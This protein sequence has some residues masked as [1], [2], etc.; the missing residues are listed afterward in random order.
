MVCEKRVKS[1]EEKAAKLRLDV[2]NAVKAAGK[3]HIGGAFSMMDLLVALYHGRF[4][5]YDNNSAEA[6]ARDRFF[7]SKGHAGVGLYALLADIGYID[8]KELAAINSGQLLGEH[9]DPRIKGIESVTGSLGHSLS[10]AA[11]VVYGN[12]HD[13]QRGKCVVMMGDGECYEGSVWEGAIFAAHHGLSNL[14]VILDR[15]GLISNGRTEQEN[16]LDPISDKWTA[17]GWD[18]RAVDGHDM[19]S[20]LVE[21]E[22]FFAE[23]QNATQKPK[24]LIADTIKGRGVSF[25]ENVVGWHH[26]GLSDEEYEIANAELSLKRV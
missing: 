10:V 17:F 14:Y 7:L 18:V 8:P 21:Y 24:I 19:R 1:L 5:N 11:G 12:R 15:N 9:P 6:D 22:L 13:K 23:D 16:A 4:L 3:G 26:G 2:I 25:M 20:I